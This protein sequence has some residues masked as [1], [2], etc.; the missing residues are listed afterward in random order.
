M[1]RIGAVPNVSTASNRTNTCD[2]SLDGAWDSRADVPEHLFQPLMSE[3]CNSAREYVSQN[4]WTT[5][6]FPTSLANLG[7]R[8]VDAVVGSVMPGVQ[9]GAS[10]NANGGVRTLRPQDAAPIT[11]CASGTAFLRFILRACD[12]SG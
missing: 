1:E 10:L 5:G 8:V 4:S 7:G 2:G 11:S 3:Q 12:V 6:M 9:F